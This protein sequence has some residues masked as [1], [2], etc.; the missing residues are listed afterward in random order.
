MRIVICAKLFRCADMFSANNV[1]AKHNAC[2]AEILPSKH[3]RRKLPPLQKPLFHRAFL[4]FS[5]VHS[6]ERRALFSVATNSR[7]DRVIALH[8]VTSCA[9]T[10]FVA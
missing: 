7:F 5:N 2:S 4:N 3:A 9:H 6:S 1:N 10:R 8:R